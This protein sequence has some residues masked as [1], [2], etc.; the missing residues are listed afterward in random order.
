MSLAPIAGQLWAR[1]AVS[2]RQR[3]LPRA[4]EGGESR[5]RSEVI[6]IATCL[7]SSIAAA[8]ASAASG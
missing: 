6:S 7:S 2:V 8:T 4:A 1:L 5:Y 3:P